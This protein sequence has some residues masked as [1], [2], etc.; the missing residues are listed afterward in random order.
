MLR[1]IHK[2]LLYF[3][4]ALMSDVE[5]RGLYYDYLFIDNKN[6]LFNFDK[7][8]RQFVKYG[9]NIPET[10]VT[11]IIK[12][13]KQ[14]IYLWN[15]ET[16]N[17]KIV[18]SDIGFYFQK[19]DR[20]FILNTSTA[21]RLVAILDN[22]QLI[23]LYRFPSK[24]TGKYAEEHEKAIK[25]RLNQ[26]KFLKMISIYDVANKCV[27]LINQLEL[28]YPKNNFSDIQI[29]GF[30]NQSFRMKNEEK[31][32]SVKLK[33]KGIF[34]DKL[35]DLFLGEIEVAKANYNRIVSLL[36]EEK[37]IE[38]INDKFKWKVPFSESEL[39]KKKALCTLLFILQDKDYIKNEL[40]NVEMVKMIENTF[41]NISFTSKTYGIN[42]KNHCSESQYSKAF[43]FIN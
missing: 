22:G 37:F 12:L 41:T 40:P 27:Q 31:P 35:R 9:S 3:L 11:P 26:A 1:K 33:N 8:D 20:S 24:K 28:E 42:K 19:V 23:N 38:S 13:A 7:L 16:S 39:S 18:K 6:D 43:H 36:K 14:I 4:K 5:T 17:D 25:D 21:F 30:T 10:K 29:I 15:E 32:D 2:Q 34:Q